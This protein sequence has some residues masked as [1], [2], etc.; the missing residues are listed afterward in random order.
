MSQLAVG[1]G[2]VCAL[3][4][5]GSV[6]C[7]GLGVDG[8]L[9]NNLSTVSSTAVPVSGLPSGIT[10]ITAGFDHACAAFLPHAVRVALKAE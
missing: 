3:T 6:Q 8:E 10:A 2:F 1:S 5:A 4:T 7:W 9:G